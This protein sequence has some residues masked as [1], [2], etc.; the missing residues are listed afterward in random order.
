MPTLTIPL[1]TRTIER[2]KFMLNDDALSGLTWSDLEQA[3]E[4]VASP[5]NLPLVRDFVT[6]LWADSNRLSQESRGF[7][8]ETHTLVNILAASILLA[9]PGCFPGSGDA[10]ASPS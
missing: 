5:V 4:E 8:P 2:P 3:L 6:A 9:G 1:P 7:L 10:P